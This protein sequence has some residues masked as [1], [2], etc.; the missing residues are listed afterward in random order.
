MTHELLVLYILRTYVYI[1]IY[2]YIY[3]L[4]ITLLVVEY[5][6]IVMHTIININYL[7]F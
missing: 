6:H 4:Y 3:I 1:Y 2:I 7:L 5:S